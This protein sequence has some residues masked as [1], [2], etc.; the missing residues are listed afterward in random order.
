MSEDESA[1]AVASASPLGARSVAAIIGAALLVGIG[2]ASVAYW[3]ITGKWIFFAGLL[4]LAVGAVLLFS[5]LTGPDR[6]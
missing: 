5:R 3:I 1:H 6:A 4:S 2:L